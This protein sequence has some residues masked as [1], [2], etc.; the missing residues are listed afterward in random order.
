MTPGNLDSNPVPFRRIDAAEAGAFARDVLLSAG[1]PRPVVAVTTEP[2][3]ERFPIDPAA[4]AREVGAHADVVTL[5]TGDATWALSEALPTRLDVYGGAARIWWPGLSSTSDPYDHPLLFAHTADQEALVIRR[6]TAA[7][8][9]GDPRAGR[10]G[11]WRP[12]GAG[13][14]REERPGDR[15]RVSARIDAAPRAATK[16]G[17]PVGM[18]TVTAIDGGLIRV[19]LGDTEGMVRFADEKLDVLAERLAV[20]QAIPVFQV[21]SRPGEPARFSTQGLLGRRT[22][23]QVVGDAVSRPRRGPDPWQRLA[24]VYEVGNV[25]RGRICRVEAKFVLVE[26][27]PGAA[28]LAPLSE[29]DW[30]FVKDP[31]ELF[32]VGD[33]VKAK[34][35]SLD[36]DER[37][38]TVSIK[39]AYAT[40]VLPAV[41]PGP[42]EPPFLGDGDEP[43]QE[44]TEEEPAG[45]DLAARVSQLTEELESAIA[46][47]AE[48]MKRVRELRK[49]LRSAEDRL[50][51]AAD[52]TDPTASETAFLTAVRVEYARRF[53]ESD[54]QRYPL[55]RMRVGR[56]FLA[57]VRCLHGVS[58]EK[59]VE[60]CAQV[61]CLRAHEIPAR[62]VHE[63]RSGGGGAPARARASDGAKAWRCSLQDGT[64]SARRLHW[65][66]VPGKEGRTIEFASV[67]VHDDFFIPA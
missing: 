18:A 17:K 11:P 33:R 24:E 22:S 51:A 14:A 44:A 4:V 41:S 8:R 54:R 21:A 42:G 23:R 67:A 15:A 29:L 64:P 7:V 16:A 12:A 48:L 30:T 57:L 43:D 59:V 39:Q 47:R 37:R 9:D 62:E 19:R 5:E 3:S 27:L 10:Y 6:I 61:A 40:E 53:N 63:L 52:E 31:A 25:V 46:D 49:D 32:S 56:A 38:G 13:S 66:D 34:I 55:Q 65:W 1:R 36:P 60:V 2:H 28:L 50:R 26:I 35:L 45:N 58:V 20:G